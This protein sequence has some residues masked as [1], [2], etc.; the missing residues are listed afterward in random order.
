[1]TEVGHEK[2]PKNEKVSKSFW[3]FNL[4]ERCKGYQDCHPYDLL[5]ASQQQVFSKI[6]CFLSIIV[7]YS[8]LVA[9]SRHLLI[10]E[11]I[12]ILVYDFKKP[13]EFLVKHYRNYVVL[14]R[15]VLCPD[16]D[17]S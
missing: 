7:S 6:L 16:K 12:D 5:N 11:Q 3:V 14:C 15:R 13:C 4:I 1:M 17:L 9:V 2:I 8:Y 10:F